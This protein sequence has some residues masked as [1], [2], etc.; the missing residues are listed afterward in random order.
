MAKVNFSQ[1]VPTHSSFCLF[2]LLCFV[3]CFCF[4]EY[5]DSQKIYI[6]LGFDVIFKSN[7]WEGKI[8]VS[9]PLSGAR[10]AISVIFFFFSFSFS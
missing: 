5:I 10:D 8:N 1:L 6:R 9:V 2:C 4:L 7:E 3:F